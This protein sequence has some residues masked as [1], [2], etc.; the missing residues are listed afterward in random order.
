MEAI[1]EEEM[2]EPIEEEMSGSAD[3]YSED[4]E[5]AALDET[6]E[7]TAPAAGEVEAPAPPP[8][9]VVNPP[10]APVTNEQLLAQHSLR[11]NIADPALGVLVTDQVPT[12]NVSLRNVSTAETYALAL[13]PLNDVLAGPT[14][15]HFGSNLDLPEGSYAVTI[16][17]N[18]QRAVFPNVVVP[19][20]AAVA[21]APR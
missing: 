19:N 17:V 21:P 11:I 7:T 1:P 9:V 6:E 13:S 2:V 5:A 10:P 15:W 18:G 4:E 3:E 8:E 14:E 16:D 20:N 12:I